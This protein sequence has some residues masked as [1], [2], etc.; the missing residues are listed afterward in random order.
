MDVILQEAS[1]SPVPP[2][3]PVAAHFQA[4][5]YYHIARLVYKKLAKVH[6]NFSYFIADMDTRLI[7]LI[8]NKL[9]LHML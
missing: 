3:K 8:V 2:E 6:F 7:L 4:Q 9:C 5:L 1:S